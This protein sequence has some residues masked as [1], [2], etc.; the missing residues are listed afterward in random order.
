MI[1]G[2]IKTL[3][4]I[5]VITV[6]LIFYLSLVGV[7]T[8]KLNKHIKSQVS[9]INKAINLEL[10]TVKL[11]VNLR[12]LSIKVK[13]NQPKIFIDNNELEFESITT[14]I[15]IKSLINKEFL[16]DDLEIS[17]KAI[18]LKDLILLARSVKNLPQLFLLDNVIN[19]G[20]LIGDISLNF[21]VNGKIKDDYEIKGFVKKAKLDI[22]KK[23]S[24]EDLNFFF[25][26]KDQNYYIENID[27]F[28][29]KINL[30]AP[31][32][33]VEKKD[34]QFFV[35][36]KFT[37]NKE[38]INIELLN[39]LLGDIYKGNNIEEIIFS[40]DNDFKFS[41]NKKLKV[42]NFILKS[43]INFNKLV[44]RN[45][46]LPI[47]NYLPDF[48]ELMEFE[49]HLISIDYKKNEIKVNGKGKIKIDD[50][51]TK[52]N[53]RID[54]N[55]DKY[56]FDTNINI[57]KNLLKLPSLM[58]EKKEN[59]NSL[60]NLKG[61]YKKNEG[62]DFA[63]IS[64]T[65]NKNI[66]LIENL[67]LDKNFDILSIKKL[68]LNYINKNDIQNQIE[69]KKN[70][71]TYQITGKSFD[72]TNLLDDILNS[73]K[74]SESFSF[75]S[76]IDTSFDLKIDKTY[77]DKVSF[78][79]NLIGNISFKQNKINSLKLKSFFSNNKELSLTINTNKD[80]EKITTLFSS[81]PMPLVR[82]YKFIKGFEEGILDFYSIKKN[83]TSNSVLKITDFKL[84]EVPVLAKI[85]T[86]ASLQ[87][88][89]D[90][91]TGEGI[92]FTDFEMKFS[93]K[94]RLMTIDEIY[95]VGPAISILMDG[96]IETKKLVSLRGTLV[97]A[98]TINKSIASI[99]LLGGILVGKKAGEGVFGVSFKIK[100]TPDDLKTTVNPIKT[101][102]PRFITRTLEKIKKN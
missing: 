30:S 34:N 101:L 49:D 40:S 15:P 51:L 67:D 44:Y 74:D 57:D 77:L 97:P 52:I 43:E 71:G 94:E 27:T 90:L 13:T 63:R 86:L 35:S 22:L 60:L 58:Y 32:L 72:V 56:F 16:I 75:F 25:N 29:N 42:K 18:K 65:E 62:I 99:P 38:S 9:N 87:G 4:I 21:D 8:S 54:K 3:S 68:S 37:N 66:F 84:Q 46:S 78:V 85:L 48:N 80:N 41:V 93:K 55:K 1:K 12:N 61:V 53:Y 28:F 5:F 45:T 69:L 83:K 64:F 24:F 79:N 76:K 81:Y 91:L 33:N 50:K 23:Y 92:R 47:K 82:K 96:Y 14:N 70:K 17:T 95:A 39:D 102:T 6:V 26:I 7:N 10:K 36:G 11:L 88:I 100:G 73:E 2:L 89:A 20:Y 19:S 31:T 59:I 98:T